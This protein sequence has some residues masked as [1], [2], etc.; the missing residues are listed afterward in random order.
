MA[1]YTVSVDVFV[2]SD[3]DRVTQKHVE[4]AIREQILLPPGL[5]I[6]G[7]DTP[8]IIGGTVSGVS[9]SAKGPELESGFG[10]DYPDDDE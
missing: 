7:I 5:S 6:L 3:D 10:R 2:S 8:A 1:Y 9:K 4:E